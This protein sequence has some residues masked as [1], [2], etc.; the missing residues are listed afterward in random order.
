MG[1]GSPF[2][3]LPVCAMLMCLLGAA[4]GSSDKRCPCPEIPKRND[5]QPPAKNCFQINETFRYVCKEPNLRKAGTS[6]FIKC[7]KIDNN[8]QWSPPTVS[9]ECIPN[10]TR[11]TQQP[12]SSTVAPDPNRAK[13]QPPSSTVAQGH[14]DIPHD[15]TIATTV[16]EFS[17]PSSPQMTPSLSTSASVSAEPDGAGPTSP[18]LQAPSGRSQAGKEED[19]TGTEAPPSTPATFTSGSTAMIGCLSVAIVCALI[20]ISFF[21]YKRRSNRNVPQQTPEETM[22]MNTVL[23]KN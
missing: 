20:G 23:A 9:L 12:P 1:L 10:P 18:G 11:T 7:K 19:V 5:T 22:P 21:C 15:F 8:K 16:S 3:L 17:A 4:R 14:T 6:G 13:T 2:A